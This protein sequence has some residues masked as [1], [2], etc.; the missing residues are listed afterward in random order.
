VAGLDHP[1]FATDTAALGTRHSTA[2]LLRKSDAF[3]TL[4]SHL[5]NPGVQ[6]QL[7]L[8]CAF[9]RAFGE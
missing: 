7:A 8:E 6:E 3:E 2:T 9:L 5:G 4:R 1:S